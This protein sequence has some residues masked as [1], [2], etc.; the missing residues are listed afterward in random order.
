LAVD[1]DERVNLEVLLFVDEALSELVD[2]LHVHVSALLKE[3]NVL[4]SSNLSL[5]HYSFVV[6]VEPDLVVVGE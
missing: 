1:V 2:L 6:L 4:A 5:F 3:L